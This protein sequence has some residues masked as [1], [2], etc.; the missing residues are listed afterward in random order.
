MGD[1][2]LESLK[3]FFKNNKEL[4]KEKDKIYRQKNIDKI[5]ARKNTIESKAKKAVHDKN[6]VNKNKSNPSFIIGKRLRSQISSNVKNGV[7][8]NNSIKILGY[9][10]NDLRLHLES[11]FTDG[12]TWDNYGRKGWHID[13]IKPL[14]MFDLSTEDGIK[15]AWSLSNLQPLWESDNLS[16]N[17]IYMGVKRFRSNL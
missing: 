8:K 3:E 7:K 4:K 13:H 1:S 12:M 6:Y 2:G 5:K 16:K 10:I 9:T 11:M 14:A 15:E 17:S